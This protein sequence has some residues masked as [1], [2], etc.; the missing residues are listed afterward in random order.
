M[1]LNATTTV[2]GVSERIER[3]PT[4]SSGSL[5]SKRRISTSRERVL[6]E[7]QRVDGAEQ[8]D[9]A[10]LAGEQEA[11]PRR[12]ALGVVGP[13]HLVEDE[14][15][16]APGA[17]STVQQT[18]GASVVDALLAG[19]EPDL[20]L[21]E[22]GG[23]A[24]VRLLGEHPQRAGVDAAALLGEE[25][26]RVRA[27]CP[28]SSARGARRRSPARRVRSGRR[29]SIPRSARRGRGA[30]ARPA[31]PRRSER[32]GR[33]VLAPVAASGHRPKLAGG[34]AAHRADAGT[35]S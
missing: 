11:R 19:D 6:D 33:F 23:E 26:E 5:R 3:S 8:E 7:R 24:P 29:I 12:A 30:G 17:I 2:P 20:L 28:S 21:A 15:L 32:L 22:L 9:V 25:L 10:V 35:T 1:R 18:I 31:P 16:P 4:N 13:L 14:H 27:S 34:Y